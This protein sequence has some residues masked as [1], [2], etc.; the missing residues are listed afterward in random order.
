MDMTFDFHQPGLATIDGPALIDR[1]LDDEPESKTD[2]ERFSGSRLRTFG[3]TQT[4]VARRVRP[5]RRS[6]VILGLEGALVDTREAST[7][8]W[9][10]ALH[11][12]GHDVSIDLLRHLSGV[13]GDELLRIVAGLTADSPEGLGILRQQERIFRTWYL[14]RILPFVGARRLL[15]RMKS[16]GLRVVALS[17]GSSETAPE[18]VR[19]SGVADLLDDIVA[20]D[21]GPRDAALNEIITS[22]MV[23]CGCKRDGIVLVGDSPYDVSAGER[24]GIDVV[25]LR[26]G[27]WTDA[28]LQGALAVYEDHVHLLSQ[29]QTSPLGALGTMRASPD[30]R[31][32]RVQ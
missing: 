32:A 8:S 16:D 20:A 17:G 21:G 29:F 26:C 13:A 6:A 5:R 30:Y 12:G 24:A 2:V 28:S 7:L 31:L 14:P 27:G 15:Q 9:L 19:A 22:L 18:L 10:V 3:A 4:A 23:T 11:D 1:S 25:A